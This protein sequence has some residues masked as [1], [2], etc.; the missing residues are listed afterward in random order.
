MKYSKIKQLINDCNNIGVD[1]WR[2]VVEN[3]NNG[4]ND[5]EVDNHRFINS[6]NI[7]EI[8]Q[9]ELESDLYILGCFNSSFLASILDIDQDVLEAMKEAEA[10]EAIGKLIISLDKLE[11]VQEQYA[12]ADGYGHHFAHYDHNEHALT[13]HNYLVF[14]V[15]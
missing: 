2:D 6:N 14:R 8:Q 13:D 1:D 15:N 7:D 12:S 4:E 11:E 9:E 3:L 5:F 10:F